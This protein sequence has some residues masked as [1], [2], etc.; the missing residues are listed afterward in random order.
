KSGLRYTT[1]VALLLAY[2]AAI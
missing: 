2:F 1:A